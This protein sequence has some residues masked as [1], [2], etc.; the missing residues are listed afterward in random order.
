MPAITICAFLSDFRRQHGEGD[1]DLPVLSV[2]EGLTLF[3]QM[4][5]RCS[6]HDIDSYLS[7]ELRTPQSDSVIREEDGIPVKHNTTSK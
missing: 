7:L 3:L 2:G 5:G 1:D 4:Y 6:W